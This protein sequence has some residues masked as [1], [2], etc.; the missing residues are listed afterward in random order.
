MSPPP[1][2]LDWKSG[3][4]GRQGK[5]TI[6]DWYMQ[7]GEMANGLPPSCNTK[8]TGLVTVGRVEGNR[9]KIKLAVLAVLSV[10]SKAEKGVWCSC[11]SETKGEG[12]SFVQ[13]ISLKVLEPNGLVSLMT[14]P[15]PQS[16]GDTVHSK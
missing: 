11:I 12:P 8:S 7:M 10:G 13:Q 16:H 2:V 1:C 15:P 9:H 14:L 4:L 3:D 5:E 6:S